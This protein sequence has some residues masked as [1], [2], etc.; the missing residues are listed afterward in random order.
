[1]V[2]YR[3]LLANYPNCELAKD[4][5]WMIRNIES[6]G[7]LMPKFDDSVGVSDSSKTS[8]PA[9]TSAPATSSKP[10]KA[11]PVT[12]A[13]ATTNSSATKPASGT[14][15]TKEGAKVR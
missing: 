9:P 10:S 15:A 1:M 6:G 7:A 14:T 12:S 11:S 2:E 13:K 3:K 8:A 5:D 4:A